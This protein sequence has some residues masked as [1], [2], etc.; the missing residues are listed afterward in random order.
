LERARGCRV[1]AEGSQ[2]FY[3]RIANQADRV[4]V[5]SIL[6]ANGYSVQPVRRKK[7]GRSYEY[8][9]KF[10]IGQQDVEDVEVPE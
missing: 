6:Y 7:N 10:W 9:V 4:T 2:V 1:M 8:L 3:L 5:A